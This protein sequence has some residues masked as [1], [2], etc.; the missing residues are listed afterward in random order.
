MAHAVDFLI[1]L[2]ALP[3]DEHDVFGRGREN[4]LVNRFAA[5]RLHKGGRTAEARGDVAKNRF[6][7]LGAGIVARD[8]DAVGLGFGQR[9][10]PRTLAMGRRFASAFTRASGVWA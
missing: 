4:R 9:R 10:P 2:V 5:V 6:G 3:R 1:V 8:D 7:R